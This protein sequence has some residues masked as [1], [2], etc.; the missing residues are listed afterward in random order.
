MFTK[1][2]IRE[3]GAWKV[4]DEGHRPKTTAQPGH[5]DRRYPTEQKEYEKLMRH[6]SYRRI[7]RRLRQT[8]WADRT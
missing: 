4:K 6:D 1:V 8:K 5:P 3:R 7:H 2:N